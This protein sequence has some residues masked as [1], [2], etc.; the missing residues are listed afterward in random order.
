V[1]NRIRPRCPKCERV[2]SPVYRRRDRAKTFARVPDVFWC[3]EG[4]SV[5]KGR[6]KSRFL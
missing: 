6:S 3:P 4:H 2:M 1:P 5:A